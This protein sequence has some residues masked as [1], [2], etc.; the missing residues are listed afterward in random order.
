MCG[1][2][3]ITGGTEQIRRAGDEHVLR[4]LRRRGPDSSN[5]LSTTT[6]TTLFHARLSIIDTSSHSSQPFSYVEN[7]DALVFNGEI[8][9]YRELGKNISSL[10]TTGDVEVLYRLLREKREEALPLLNGFFAFAYCTDEG[11]V[12]L[13]RDRFGEKP[14]YY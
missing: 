7:N 14:L 4:I 11:E 1:I 8:F 13:A 10:R 2:A 6:G 9:N 5:V 12:L 3:G